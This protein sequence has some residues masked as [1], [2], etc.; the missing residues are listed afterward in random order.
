MR[1]D[2]ERKINKAKEE[3]GALMDQLNIL[4]EA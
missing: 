1:K 4:R 2:I 3:I